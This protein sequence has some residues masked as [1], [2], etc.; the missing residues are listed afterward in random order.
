MTCFDEDDGQITYAIEFS[1]DIYNLITPSSTNNL[2]PGTYEFLVQND[3]GCFF[4]STIIITEPDLVVIKESVEII[5][6]STDLANIVI[7]GSG[8]VMPYSISWDY[9]DTIFNP[10]LGVGVYELCLYR[11]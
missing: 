9:G 4:D 7:E 1:T 11:C 3:Q 2:A 5:C 10:S 8:G 6:E